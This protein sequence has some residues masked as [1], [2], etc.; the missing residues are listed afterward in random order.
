VET[1]CPDRDIAVTS[2]VQAT[3]RS[4]AFTRDLEAAYLDRLAEAATT[5][6]WEAGQ[7]VFREGDRDEALYLVVEGAVAIDISVP[8]RGHVRILTVGPGE[9]FGWSSVYYQKPKT[10]GA[11]AIERVQALALDAARLRE[12]SESDPRFGY[13]LARRL[14]QVVSE[15]LK[16]TR[17]QLLDVFQ[18]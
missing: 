4:L 18:T 6:H 5:V 14:L 12:L 7:S 17:I 16:A 9:V 8:R 15:R 13:W 1:R 10:A 11:T 3:L 2:N